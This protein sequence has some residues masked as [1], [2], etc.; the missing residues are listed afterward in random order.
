[1]ERNFGPTTHLPLYVS[2]GSHKSLQISEESKKN[3]GVAP[4][5]PGLLFSSKAQNNHNYNKIYKRH[6][7]NTYSHASF[8]TLSVVCECFCH[9]ETTEYLHF[10]N[11]YKY[12]VLVKTV[13]FHKQ[14]FLAFQSHLL[15]LCHLWSGFVLSC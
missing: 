11:N 13:P 10:C 2:L 1:M 8:W 6:P 15:I 12:Y 3:S 9:K 4:Y 14:L 5:A 7:H